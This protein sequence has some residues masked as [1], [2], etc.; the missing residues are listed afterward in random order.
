MT[1]IRINKPADPFAPE[2]AA[3]LE[4]MRRRAGMPEK[5]E[6]QP[7]VKYGRL[8][9]FIVGLRRLADQIEGRV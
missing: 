9:P 6:T 2:I 3:R 8:T 1:Q 7:A 5:A 4:I